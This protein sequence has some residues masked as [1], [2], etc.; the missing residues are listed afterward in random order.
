MVGH[1]RVD[2]VRDE[3]DV[4]VGVGDREGQ[5]TGSHH[6]PI[7]G[8]AVV[9]VRQGL[10]VGQDDALLV[11]AVLACRPRPIGLQ[12]RRCLRGSS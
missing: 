10:R 6:L 7:R 1:Q 12:P 9:G 4:A 8:P 2:E 11:G 3:V 5:V